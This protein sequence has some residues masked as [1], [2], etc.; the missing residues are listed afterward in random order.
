MTNG[1]F[2]S[3]KTIISLILLALLNLPVLVSAQ[4]KGDALKVEKGRE[5]YSAICA[6]CHDK[7]GRGE[8]IGLKITDHRP[9][10]FVNYNTMSKLNDD[11]LFKYITGGKGLKSQRH[12]PAWITALREEAVWDVIAYIR[13]LSAPDRKGSL[14]AGN[15]RFKTYCI[16]CHGMKGKGDGPIAK[17]LMKLGTLKVKPRNFTDKK[18]M[19]KKTDEQLFRVI[20]RG[21]ASNH[22]SRYM[23][24]YGSFADRDIWDLIAYIRNFSK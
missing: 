19:D 10:D 21:G 4:E 22:L 5:V 13:T 24:K 23:A 16:G 12:N 6:V 3:H 15:D 1:S 8:G 2:Y 9:L 14:Q 7:Y 11:V 17:S 20:L 18:V